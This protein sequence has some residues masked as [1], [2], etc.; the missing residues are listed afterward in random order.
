[1]D[2]KVEKRKLSEISASGYWS[3]RDFERILS[4]IFSSGKRGKVFHK[5]ETFETIENSREA[6]S[7]LKTSLNVL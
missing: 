4:R 7:L 3:I 5:C 1:M 2:K 6:V